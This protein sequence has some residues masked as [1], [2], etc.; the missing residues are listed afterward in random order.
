M[1]NGSK[2]NSGKG[3]EKSGQFVNTA[4][5]AIAK[6]V[7]A[8]H[9]GS[10]A[11]IV[12]RIA[13]RSEVK[14]NTVSY[15]SIDVEPQ[16]YAITHVINRLRDAHIPLLEKKK[17]LELLEQTDAVKDSIFIIKLR[18]DMLIIVETKLLTPVFEEYER[19]ELPVGECRP[20]ELIAMYKQ[21]QTLFIDAVMQGI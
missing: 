15:S 4:L 11:D 21:S 5:D 13:A 20:G 9:K 17:E 7:P 1:S 14:K 6:S 2:K 8:E 12:R 10:P 3:Q 16:L 18:L 19:L